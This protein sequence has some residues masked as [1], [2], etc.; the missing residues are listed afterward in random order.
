MDQCIPFLPHGSDENNK[1]H[2]EIDHLS[3]NIPV[4]LSQPHGFNPKPTTK[5]IY[6]WWGDQLDAD[7]GTVVNGGYRVHE[8]KDGAGFVARV[9]LQFD[10]DVINTVRWM[11]DVRNFRDEGT[12]DSLKLVYMAGLKDLTTGYAIGRAEEFGGYI[13]K[14][15]GVRKQSAWGTAGTVA[16]DLEVRSVGGHAIRAYLVTTGYATL[17]SLGIIW[18]VSPA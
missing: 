9:D 7:T 1:F 6:R 17:Y 5:D 15:A 16:R 11:V 4:R 13:D 8:A 10:V 3:R 18:E 2:Q 12:D 14:P